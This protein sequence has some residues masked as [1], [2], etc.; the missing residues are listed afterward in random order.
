MLRNLSKGIARD[1]KN[2][3]PNGSL[4]TERTLLTVCLLTVSQVLNFLSGGFRGDRKQ[5]KTCTSTG[6]LWLGL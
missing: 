5:V 1:G 6:V 3:G 4:A 2:M